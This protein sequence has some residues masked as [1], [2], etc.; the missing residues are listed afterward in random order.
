MAVADLVAPT[1][2]YQS[3]EDYRRW[4]VSGKDDYREPDEKFVAPNEA[5]I[6]ANYDIMIEGERQREVSRAKNTLIKSFGWILIP[7]GIFIFYQR[8]LINSKA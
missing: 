3:Y 4:E 2:Y 5:E 8:N 7:F 1:P 6:K